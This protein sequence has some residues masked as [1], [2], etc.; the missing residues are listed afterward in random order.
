MPTSE[1]VERLVTLGGDNKL[2]FSGGSRALT[3]TAEDRAV[4]KLLATA[5]M[6]RENR[7]RVGARPFSFRRRSPEENALVHMPVAEAFALLIQE[8]PRLRA[9]ETEAAEAATRARLAGQGDSGVRTAVD[10]VVSRVILHD[11]VI[12]PSASGLCATRSA[13]LVVTEHLYSVAGLSSTNLD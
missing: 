2:A 12:G 6:V 4:L 11:S 8:E 13:L 3:R 1:A 7:N 5:S 9:A 10:E